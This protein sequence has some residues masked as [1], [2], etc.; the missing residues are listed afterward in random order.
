MLPCMEAVGAPE[1]QAKSR[2]YFN[3][4]FMPLPEF[5]YWLVSGLLSTLNWLLGGMLG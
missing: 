1:N 3:I 4:F 5:L 2:G